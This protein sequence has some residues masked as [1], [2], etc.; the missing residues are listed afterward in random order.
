M[1]VMHALFVSAEAEGKAKMAVEKER[2]GRQRCA[3]LTSRV[4]GLE[5]Q[6]IALR[7]EV[8]TEAALSKENL[9]KREKYVF[10]DV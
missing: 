3:T 10:L 2:S 7:K 4:S 6:L 1:I 9:Q 5:S 8:E